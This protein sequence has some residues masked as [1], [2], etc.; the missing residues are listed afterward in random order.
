[1][2]SESAGIV[3]EVH[4]KEQAIEKPVWKR[5]LLCALAVAAGISFTLRIHQLLEALLFCDTNSS[6][7]NGAA[8]GST[9]NTA[10]LYPTRCFGAIF[11][12]SPPA[13]T[14][15]FLVIGRCFGIS[16]MT[17]Q[18]A[19]SAWKRVLPPNIF[20]LARQRIFCI[21]DTQDTREI[22][23]DTVRSAKEKSAIFNSY[24]GSGVS[25]QNLGSLP[26]ALR[27]DP[28]FPQSMGLPDVSAL[29]RG[30]RRAL[31]VARKDK[32]QR[33]T[34]LDYGCTDESALGGI[35]VSA[36]GKGVENNRVRII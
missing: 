3:R 26:S 16:S 10:P 20:E 28:A 36:A 21:F 18:L 35:T 22:K 5:V 33:A 12:V 30:R 23:S 9:T 25:G 8:D 31:R 24:V 29:T 15:A 32:S 2:A 14:M 13:F 34:P 4:T 19:E 11:F 17:K 1:M 6:T 7:G 27:S